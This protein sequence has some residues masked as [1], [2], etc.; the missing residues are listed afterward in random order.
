LQRLGRLIGEVARLLI[1][2]CE[3]VNLHQPDVDTDAGEMQRYPGL[4]RFSANFL[5]KVAAAFRATLVVTT[6]RVNRTAE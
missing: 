4:G 5:A 6:T 2:S 1:G 3:R